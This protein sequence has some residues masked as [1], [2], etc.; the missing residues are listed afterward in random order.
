ILTRIAFPPFTVVPNTLFLAKFHHKPAI[1]YT[2]AIDVPG[3]S[4]PLYSWDIYGM[5]MGHLWDIYGISCP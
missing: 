5:S 1:S 2:S 3:I 4:Q